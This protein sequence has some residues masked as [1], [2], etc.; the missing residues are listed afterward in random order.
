[1]DIYVQIL[2]IAVCTFEVFIP[3]E[4]VITLGFGANL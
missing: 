1:M 4:D 2:F 3:I